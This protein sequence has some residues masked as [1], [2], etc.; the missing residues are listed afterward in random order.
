[1]WDL[2][3]VW[4]DIDATAI[5]ATGTSGDDAHRNLFATTAHFEMRS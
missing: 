3:S 2:G 4:M 5:G 1:M